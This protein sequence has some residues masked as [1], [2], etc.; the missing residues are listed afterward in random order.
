MH[1]R[2]SNDTAQRAQHAQ[3]AEQAQHAQ[4]AK[5]E[6]SGRNSKQPTQLPEDIESLLPPEW[7]GKASEVDASKKK[8]KQKGKLSLTAQYLHGETSQPASHAAQYHR[9]KQP[10]NNGSRHG[11]A[12]P[13]TQSRSQPGK[14][15]NAPSSSYNMPANIPTS[16]QALPKMSHAHSFQDWM[17][18][19]ASDQQ[20]PSGAYQ[21]MAVT[22]GDAPPPWFQPQSQSQAPA[23]QL[24]A[25]AQPQSTLSTTS[26]AYPKGIPTPA[27]PRDALPWN[28][29]LPARPH[30]RSEERL[31]QLA[32]LH[33]KVPEA[34]GNNNP[35]KPRSRSP[36]PMLLE[37]DDLEAELGPVQPRSD[38]VFCGFFYKLHT[39]L[40]QH[41]TCSKEGSSGSF[42]MLCIYQL[43]VPTGSSSYTKPLALN[44]LVSFQVRNKAGQP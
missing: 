23:A 31:G 32:A 22:D 2:Q 10:V 40:Q 28:S 14:E 1:G 5:Q 44:G 13:Q 7:G 17:Q 3:Q 30:T 4:Q 43:L 41:N 26:T 24:S 18:D 38:D 39:A 33:H 11:R 35:G 34:A 36:S 21:S 16:S 9:S 20:P 42:L 19:P 27:A 6:V 37:D 15:P 8:G 25:S 29:A 12:Q